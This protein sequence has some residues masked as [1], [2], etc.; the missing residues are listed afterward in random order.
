MKWTAWVANAAAEA[1]EKLGDSVAYL[2]GKF[3]VAPSDPQVD[4]AQAKAKAAVDKIE[5]I[6]ADLIDELPGVP[7]VVATLGAH[8]AAQLVDAAIAAA[9]DT[10][11]ANN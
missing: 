5:A 8:A 11:K 2:K 4:A 10:V 1:K 6:L 3:G 9:A 7:R